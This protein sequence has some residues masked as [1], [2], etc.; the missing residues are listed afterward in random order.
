MDSEGAKKH[1]LHLK[2]TRQ[3]PVDGMTKKY[4]KQNTEDTA[5]CCVRN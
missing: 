2:E 1:R 4:I 3:E 5:K